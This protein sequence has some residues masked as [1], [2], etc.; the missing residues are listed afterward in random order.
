M[1]DGIFYVLRTGCQWKA[2]LKEFGSGR[3]LHRYF[4]ELAR[5]HIFHKLWK[6]LLRRCDALR[7]I[8]WKWQSLDGST[9]KA[10]LG[11]KKPG[12]TPRIEANWASSGRCRPMAEGGHRP[13]MRM[14]SGSFTRR[15]IASLSV[16][17]VPLRSGDSISAATTASM[18]TPSAAKPDGVATLFTS[19]RAASSRSRNVTA[20]IARLRLL[21][22]LDATMYQRRPRN[23]TPARRS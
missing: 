16:A 18:R 15:S 17:L 4:Q 20:P 1:A 7:S 5:R 9:T 13:P 3:S 12:R 23:P 21:L 6:C 14:T 19:R 2:A 11:W 8:Q 22:R 10:P